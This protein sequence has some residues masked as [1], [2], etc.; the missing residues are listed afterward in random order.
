VP[1]FIQQ[2]SI[3]MIPTETKDL[4]HKA[5]FVILTNQIPPWMTTS[6]REGPKSLP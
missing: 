5:G 1:H 2:L 4:K 3:N 6:W